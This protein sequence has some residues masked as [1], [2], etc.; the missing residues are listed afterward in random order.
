MMPQ[1]SSQITH[2]GRVDEFDQAK[3]CGETD[4]RPEI[5]GC[6][7]AAE[8]D[9]LEAF[10]TSEALFDSCAGLVERLGEKGGLVLFVSFVRDHRSNAAGPRRRAIC[11]A[12]ITL[13]TNGGAG[14]DVRPDVEQGFEV[15]GVRGFAARQVE[16]DDVARRIGFCVDFCCEPAARAPERLIFLPPFAPAAETCARTIVESNIWI[17]RADELT[18]ASV[19]K[20]GSNTPAL[21]RRSNR[22]Q[23]LFQGPKRS[24]R[25]RQRTFSTVK[26][27]IASR[28]K[29]SSVAFRPRRGKQVRKT[30][31]V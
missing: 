29:R 14:L 28:N 26:K 11:L 25:A 16:G 30:V 5:S 17:R 19:S 8:S 6:L 20:N 10:E 4:D 13:V 2:L 27:C 24:G 7:F 9:P 31:S 15:A 22:F 12:G 21:L 18:E 23:T 3:G 1:S